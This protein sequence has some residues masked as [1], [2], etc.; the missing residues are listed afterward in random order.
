MK[1]LL[2]FVAALAL[3]VGFSVDA[4]AQGANPVVQDLEVEVLLWETLK[5]ESNPGQLSLT[6]NPGDPQDQASVGT[7]LNYQTNS[8]EERVITM[9]SSDPVSGP[10]FTVEIEGANLSDLD[11]G[12]GGTGGSLVGGDN[13][14]GANLDDFVDN[15][16]T[17]V[18][19]ITQARGTL[20]LNYHIDL[21]DGQS[22]NGRLAA[23]Q[24]EQTQITFTLQGV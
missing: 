21:G 23:V 4:R 11:V 13:L 17:I 7:V 18:N 6:L 5:I 1:K 19:G 10:D 2:S 9:E 16:T 22:E 3:I 15:P 8:T 20:S 24:S 12:T 14:G